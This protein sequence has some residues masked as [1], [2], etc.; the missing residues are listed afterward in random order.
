MRSNLAK[1]GRGGFFLVPAQILGPEFSHRPRKTR[2]GDQG[3]QANQPQPVVVPAK[4]RRA[5]STSE[6]NIGDQSHQQTTN[7]T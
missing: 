7:C 6:D 1:Y 3:E 2:G 4:Q 5:K